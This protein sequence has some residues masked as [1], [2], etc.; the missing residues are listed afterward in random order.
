MSLPE[1]EAQVDEIDMW[2]SDEDA[3]DADPVDSQKRRDRAI[4]A[5]IEHHRSRNSMFDAYCH[6]LGLGT[7]ACLPLLDSIPCLPSSVFKSLPE[8][9]RSETGDGVI[10]TSSGTQ[11][12]VSRVFRDDVTLMRFFGTIAASIRRLLDI[13]NSETKVYNLGPTVE[14]SQHLWISYVMAGVSLVHDSEFYVDSN[15]L[16]R[17]AAMEDLADHKGR[18]AVL[19]GPP[20]LVVDLAQYVRDQ[21]GLDLSADL[22]VV[23]IGGWKKRTSE[24]VSRPDLE[25]LVAEAFQVERDGGVRDAFNMVE[26]NTVIME[27]EHRTFHV[28]PWLLARARDPKTLKTLK[29]GETGILAYADPTAT[30]YPCFVLSDDFGSV[31]EAETCACGIT[32]DVLRVERRINKL[33]TRGCALKI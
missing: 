18:P 27:C 33:E 24:R 22:T 28:P 5:A 31:R 13:E 32:G 29:P 11:G 8:P 2:L 7:G 6:R 12:S 26:L 3:F 14:Q 25:R 23:T 30:S 20:A 1:A 15:V 19:V 4:R 17:R 16:D 10:T 9:V 21:G